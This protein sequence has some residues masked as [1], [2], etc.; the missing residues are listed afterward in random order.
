MSAHGV[1]RLGL[2]VPPESRCVPAAAQEDPGDLMA[3]LF[4]DWVLGSRWVVL[5]VGSG[6]CV[7]GT[8]EIF[9]F[10]GVHF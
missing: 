5:H 6:A 1:L 10:L 2:C 4:S 9:I 8:A 3:P 7:A